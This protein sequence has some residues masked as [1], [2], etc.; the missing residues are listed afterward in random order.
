VTRRRRNAG[1]TLLEVLLS[2]GLLAL[3]TS[4][5]LGG[6]RLGQRAWERG[7]DYESVHEVEEAASAIAALLQRAFPV[8]FYAQDVANVGP[9]AAFRGTSRDLR[10]VTT[11]EGG[12]AWGGLAL[13][14]IGASGADLGVW[15]SVYRAEAWRAAGR[16]SMREARA[17][18]GVETFELSYFGAEQENAP[19]RWSDSWIDRRWLP[20]L[21][22]VRLAALR[23]GRRIDASFIVAIRQTPE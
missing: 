18:A 23:H 6:L 7:R 14:E 21:V 13:T 9:V 2:I 15:T 4:S 1:F 11:S 10:L 5:I 8:V 22:S 20:R 17:L 16:G 19:P 12:A 3:I